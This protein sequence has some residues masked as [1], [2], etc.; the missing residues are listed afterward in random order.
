MRRPG[1][2]ERHTDNLFCESTATECF[3]FWAKERLSLTVYGIESSAST[4][5]NGRSCAEYT[6]T[7][8]IK[9][10]M[11]IHTS[12]IALGSG[13]SIELDTLLPLRRG[14]KSSALTTPGA[15]LDSDVVDSCGARKTSCGGVEFGQLSQ[16][17]QSLSQTPPGAFSHEWEIPAES[18][19]RDSML[20][21]IEKPGVNNCFER[22]EALETDGILHLLGREEGCGR[23]GYIRGG[24]SSFG[25][26]EFT[27]AE[28]WMPR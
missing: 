12:T 26:P 10:W 9:L 6:I 27:R 13:E 25:A 24:L 17:P 2:R 21:D 19:I 14:L 20:Q 8:A 3:S 15:H 23:P 4:N 16:T 5:E 11:R 7:P 1:P 18:P 28:I 22:K